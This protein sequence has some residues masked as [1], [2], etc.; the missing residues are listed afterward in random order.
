MTL[1]VD[2]AVLDASP[3]S[4]YASEPVLCNN[5]HQN[6]TRYRYPHAENPA[7]TQAEVL[8]WQLRRT[9]E[10]CH[11]AHSPFHDTEQTDY[12]PPTCVDC[13]GSHDV[14]SMDNIQNDMPANCLTCHTDKNNAWALGYVAPRPGFGSGAEGYIGSARCNGCHDDKYET[15]RHTLHARLIQQPSNNALAVV[16]DFNHIDP[17][18][19]FELK[20]VDYT[21]GSRWQ[22]LYMTQTVS[23]TFHIL[24]A[25]WNVAKREWEAYHP[26]DWQQREWRQECGSCHVTGLDTQ[27]GTFREFGVGC[28]SC[29]GPGA[30]HAADPEN[31]KLFAQV[32]DQVC[33]ACHSRGTSP[34]GHPYPATYRPGDTLTD[35]FTFTDTAEYVWPDGSAKQNNQQYMDWMLG[36]DKEKSGKVSC[37]TCHTVHD[38]GAGDWPAAEADQ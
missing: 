25:A 18:R 6:E 12:T 37:T 27:T 8:P 24:P 26:E 2:L 22:Q 19:N 5:C 7:Q 3:H 38:P 30:T 17:D 14:A 11:Y 13:H 21:I 29:H 20:D 23:D 32:D 1:G 16:G 4:S 28:E 31:V 10:D 35:H 36:S 34:D 33:G 15:W 9:V